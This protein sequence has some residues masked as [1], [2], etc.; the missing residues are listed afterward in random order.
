MKILKTIEKY[1]LIL[2]I[3]LTPLFL[4]PTFIDTFRTSKILIL[5]SLVGL[6]LFVKFLRT[7]NEG[8]LNI[9]SANFDFP[10]FLLGLSFLLSGIFV[11]PNKMEAFFIPGNAIVF[12]SLTLFYFLLNQSKIR[13]NTV[14]STIFYSSLVYSLVS[15]LALSGILEKIPQLPAYIKVSTFNLEGSLLPTLMFLSS[16]LP[17]IISST[18]KEKE[19]IKRFFYAVTTIFIASAIILN[20]LNITSYK[21]VKLLI[22]DFRSSWSIAVDS[23]KQNPLLGIGPG[24]YKTAFN[25][26]RP[27]SYNQTENWNTK[28][29]SARCLY[30]TI[31]TEVGLMGFA[32][33]LIMLL[34]SFKVIKLSFL[35]KKDVSIS[36]AIILILLSLFP[37][38]ISLLLILFVFLSL[39]SEKK[40]YSINLTLKNQEGQKGSYFLTRIPAILV[41]L[42]VIV[43]LIIFSF[44]GV[45]TIR[46]ELRFKKAADFLTASNAQGVYNS[47]LEAVT[48]NPYV[49]RY[50]LSYSQVSFALANSLAQKQDLTDQERETIAQLIQQAITEGKASITLNPNRSENWLNL[51]KIYQSITPFAQ[52]SDQY[53]IQT[54]SQ[55]IVLDPINP[56]IR[57]SLGGIYYSLGRYDD[58]I[59]AFELSVIAKPD[60]ANAHFNLAIA[61]K[62]KGEI[63]KAITQ[64]EIVLSLVQKDTKDYSLAKEILDD[65]E[66]K[67]PTTEQLPSENLVLPQE[68]KEPILNPPLELPE[69]AT[70][71][72]SIEE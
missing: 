53:A 21:N 50:R 70:P 55:A 63:E 48:L 19:L 44:T 38:S 60:Y 67:R 36:L 6:T 41:S 65:L 11:S 59:R 51:C 39:I 34:T 14:K 31:L 29:N 43:G 17:I 13:N 61:L 35:K 62:E 28:F 9:S 16:L 40:D 71:P 72:A 69:E 42:P 47:L 25:L 64:M 58:A 37:S 23:L 15:I 8:K 52:G 68:A 32:A 27:I 4:L 5:V 3:F 24:N 54:C 22:P 45:K 7:I 26:F 56:L 10:I 20:I 18:L 49:D 1:I 66:A 12:I 33:T 30:L 57:L 46:A 2:V